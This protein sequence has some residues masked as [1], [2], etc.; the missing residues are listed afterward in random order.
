MADSASG[1]ARPGDK[2]HQHPAHIQHQ[3]QDIF[4]QVVTVAQNVVLDDAVDVI[5]NE[6]RI[7]QRVDEVA[8]GVAVVDRVVLRV[9]VA[10]ERL[11]SLLEAGKAIPLQEASQHWMVMPRPQVD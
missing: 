6:A 3:R 1:H 4:A 9:G 2:G 7:Q 10:V 11:G 8:A 5:D